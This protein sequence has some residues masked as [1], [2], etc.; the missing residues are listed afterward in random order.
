MVPNGSFK[1]E[2]EKKFKYYLTQ[3]IQMEGSV[4]QRN[5][6]SKH[7]PTT[8]YRPMDGHERRRF[9]RVDVDEWNEKTLSHSHVRSQGCLPPPPFFSLWRAP[10]A[11]AFPGAH[12]GPESASRRVRLGAESRP[13]LHLRER[14]PHPPAGRAPGRQH[15][16]GRG[17]V[18]GADRAGRP[19]GQRHSSTAPGAC[20]FL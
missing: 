4:E 14:R 7:A 2:G 16:S 13:R 19:P 20:H 15:R 1:R 11:L 17:L 6:A 12:G 3:R 18:A 9:A 10:L 5:E 8:A